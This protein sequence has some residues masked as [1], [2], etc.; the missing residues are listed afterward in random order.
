M[1]F[2]EIL[3]IL[4][5]VSGLICLIYFVYQ[6]YKNTND[7]VTNK[8]LK[9]VIEYSRSFF[10][11]FLIVLVLRSFLY[12]PFRIPSGS[13]KPTLL[14]GDFILVNKYAYGLRLPVLGT[15]IIP[16]GQPKVGDVIV[17][18][19]PDGDDLIK[20]VVGLPGD[21]IRYV[22]K[23]L[24]INDQLVATD[25]AHLSKDGNLEVLESTERLDSIM[26]NI[27]VMPDRIEYYPYSNTIVPPNSYF[28]LGDNRANSKDSRYWGFVR[29]Q[30]LLGKAFATWISWDG[31]NKGIRWDRFG[32]S[33]YKY[34]GEQG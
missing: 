16:V 1:R 32:K 21:H 30:D 8:A 5:A 31:D 12:E 33:I 3:V 20:R 9:I 15:K 29:E 28:V 14:V 11:V 7:P 22:D 19:H 23:K 25:A 2:E 24:Y 17:F 10:P 13:M 4:T 27:Y 34:T 26:H 6:K 18:R